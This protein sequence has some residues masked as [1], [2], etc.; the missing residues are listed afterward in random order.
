MIF[1]SFWIDFGIV[2]WYFLIDLGSFWDRFQPH[3]WTFKLWARN[4]ATAQPRLLESGLTAPL[5]SSASPAPNYHWFYVFSLIFFFG[6]YFFKKTTRRRQ[7][8]QRR[9]QL[10]KY[11]ILHVSP[12]CFWCFFFQKNDPPEATPPTKFPAFKI[13]EDQNTPKYPKIFKIYNKYNVLY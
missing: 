4:P 12:I 5:P 13:P 8:R 6:T 3:L 11:L 7:R 1:G 9:S 2:S 10:L